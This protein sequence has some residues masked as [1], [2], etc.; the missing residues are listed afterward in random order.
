MSCRIP[1]LVF[2]GLF[3]ALSAC[4]RGYRASS[5][6]HGPES[7]SALSG[8]AQAGEEGVDALVEGGGVLAEF[9]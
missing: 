4:L 3:I 2:V 9:T 5:L 6:A 1:A 7:G 8:V